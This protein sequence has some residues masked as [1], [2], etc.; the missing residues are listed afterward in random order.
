MH[1]PSRFLSAAALALAVLGPSGAAAQT[2][3]PPQVAATDSRL[4]ITAGGGF[5]SLKGDCATCT[6][7]PVYRKTG[8]LMVNVGARANAQLDG[9]LELSWV[10]A[11]TQDGYDIRTT[12]LMGVGQ[13]RPLKDHGL[14]VKG[15]MGIAFVRNWVYDATNDVTP[16]FTTNAMA[17]TY[18][19][20]WEFR[21]RG[22]IGLQVYGTHSIIALGD[23]TVNAGS[24]VENVVGN[25]W[26]V[27]ASI[28]IR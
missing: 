16:P 10:P 22:R 24:T 1:T 6:G 20:G 9:A 2:A 21:S 28:V 13:Y 7:E 14:F 23:L 4:W 25:F 27:G 17:L 11:T 18:G 12:F 26:T 8:S 15:G 19:G 3:A 5:T